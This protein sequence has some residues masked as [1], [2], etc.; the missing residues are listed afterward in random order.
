MDLLDH[1]DKGATLRLEQRELLMLMAL[2]QEGRDSFGCTAE[3]GRELDTLISTANMLVEQE[4][5]AA[6]GI[7]S[8]GHKMGLVVDPDGDID[9][10]KVAH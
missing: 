3:T 2:V 6:L 10:K 4:R 9:P 5:R 7:Q 1:D 8:L